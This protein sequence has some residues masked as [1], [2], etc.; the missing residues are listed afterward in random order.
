LLL[1]WE[2]FIWLRLYYGN[3]KVNKLTF[4]SLKWALAL[5]FSNLCNYS[6]LGI[7]MYYNPNLEQNL[8]EF[9]SSWVYQLII[10]PTSAVFLF[11]LAC[12]LASVMK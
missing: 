6:F 11:T 12:F 8:S 3:F 10:L 2:L 9:Y 4:H 1:L 5:L 7:V